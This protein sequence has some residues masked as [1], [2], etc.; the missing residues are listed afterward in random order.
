MSTT[1]TFGNWLKQ[2][3]RRLELTQKELAQ[4]IP[5]AE[6][7]I[8]KLESGAIRPGKEIAERL[9]DC[10]ELTAAEREQ[11]VLVGRGLATPTFA[12]ASPPSTQPRHNL[13]EPTTAIIGRERE[14]HALRERLLRPMVELLILYVETDDLG[15]LFG[16]LQQTQHPYDVAHIEKAKAVHGIDFSQPPAGPLPEVVLQTTDSAEEDYD[17]NLAIVLPFREGGA[18]R[19][20][21]LAKAVKG[22]KYAAHQDFLRRHRF[23]ENWYIQSTP[24]G[25]WVILYLEAENLERLFFEAQ[26]TTHPYNDWHFDEAEAIHGVD[27]RKPPAGPMPE[28]LYES[29]KG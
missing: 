26:T 4:R 9:A 28:V 20:R 2:R 14:L 19:L 22:S 18:E 15:K 13:L 5:C 11:F 24:M 17:Q 29:R 3:R 27:F 16:G 10:L 12:P 8:R 21:A 6:V 25:E 23:R 1:I 7:T